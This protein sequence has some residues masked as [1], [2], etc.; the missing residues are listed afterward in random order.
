MVN[1]MLTR[2]LN[3]RQVDAVGTE[4]Q[5]NTVTGSA[6]LLVTDYADPITLNRWDKDVAKRREENQWARRKRPFK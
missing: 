2:Q 4:R 1:Q 3:N 5:S 6:Q